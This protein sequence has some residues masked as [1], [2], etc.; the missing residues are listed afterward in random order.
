MGLLQTIGV[1]ESTNPPEDVVRIMLDAALQGSNLDLRRPI[2]GIYTD[3]CSPIQI[4]P[5]ALDHQANSAR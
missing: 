3:R 4:G 5:V 2:R 1:Y